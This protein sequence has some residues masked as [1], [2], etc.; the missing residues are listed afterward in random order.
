MKSRRIKETSIAAYYLALENEIAIDLKSYELLNYKPSFL[1]ALPRP[2][3]W[4]KRVEK[5]TFAVRLASVFIWILWNL[6]GAFIYNFYEFCKWKKIA[7]KYEHEDIQKNVEA[8]NSKKEYVLVLSARAYELAGEKTLGYKPESWVYMP[9]VDV[10]EIDTKKPFIDLLSLAE[11]SDYRFAFRKSIKS[12]LYSYR[13]FFCFR[14]NL[15]NYTSYRW[16]LAYSVLNKIQ[17]GHFIMTEHFDRW[18]ILADALVCEKK[19][20]FPQ[21]TSFTV[22]QHGTLAASLHSHAGSKTGGNH[23]DFEYKNLNRLN[24]VDNLFVYDE[25]SALCFT[26]YIL[27]SSQGKEI[28]ISYFKPTIQ[29]TDFAEAKGVK[30]LFVGHPFC[31]TLHLFLLKEIQQKFG[32]KVKIYYK[33]HPQASES[34]SIHEGQWDIV[35]DKTTFPRV[36]LLISYA[37]TLVAEYDNMGV[38]AL[39]HA[40]GL[41]PEQVKDFSVEVL[42]QVKFLV[43]KSF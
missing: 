9:W 32:D 39:V 28:K 36:D 13:S 25:P 40:I 12:F 2:S 31:E 22:I 24:S 18:A 5:Y 7:K 30:I 21:T 20:T 43:E 33:P 16:F 1:G 29:L 10:V 19:N 6:G 42:T 11:A 34:D 37:S 38:P 26:Q 41:S 23:E 27:S 8:L 17:S 4:V 3:K 14:W 15:Q 35:K